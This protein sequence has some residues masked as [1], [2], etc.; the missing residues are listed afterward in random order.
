[1]PLRFKKIGKS[2][3]MKKRELF[4]L[5]LSLLTFRMRKR[6][7]D[8]N[9]VKKVLVIAL[10]RLGDAVVSIPAFRAIK[11]SLPQSEV[12]VLSNS[13]VRDILDRVDFIDRIVAY[14]KRGTFLEKARLARKLAG[15]R[16]DLAVDLTCDYTFGNA[17]VC[18][19]SGA[20]YRVGY[21]TSG[22]GF[23]FH[24]PVKHK[25]KP[26]HAVEEILDI[27]RSVG[28]DIASK[29]LRISAS[30]EAREAIKKFLEGQNIEHGDL[31]I[32]IHPGGYYPTQKWPAERFAQVGK[33]LMEKFGAK[34]VLIGGP[35]EEKWIGQVKTVMKNNCSIFLNQPVK[36][37]LALIQSCQLLL[38]NNSGPLH[39]A[40]ALGTPTVSTMGPTLPEKWGPYEEG[41]I[42]LRKDLAC[43]PCND[44]SCRLKTHDCLRLITAEEM[45]RAAEK[46]LS[47]F[48]KKG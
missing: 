36:N 12:T 28:L 16:F 26:L 39:L 23:L 41:H 45:L 1:M 25:K 20:R 46:L 8:R 48:L 4:F 34:I 6:I 3:V 27:V 2:V 9:K 24:K 11:E 21:G 22:R 17:L 19:L 37:L 33:A 44:A 7:F 40:V 38:C 42:V 13:Y 47:K 18:F 15:H 32:G 14:E 43:M 29:S 5:L 10:N 35:G 31:L 30:R